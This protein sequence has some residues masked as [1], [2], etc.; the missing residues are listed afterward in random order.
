MMYFKM[1]LLVLLVK[2]CC[3]LSERINIFCIFFSSSDSGKDSKTVA[4][5]RHTNAAVGDLD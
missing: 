2:I 4:Q 3:D 5:E 1:I